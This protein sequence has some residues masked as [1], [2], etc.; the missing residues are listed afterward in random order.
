[1]GSRCRWFRP[2]L[3]RA[4][5]FLLGFLP[6]FLLPEPAEETLPEAEPGLALVEVVEALAGRVAVPVGDAVLLVEERL[7]VVGEVA[8]LHGLVL[9]RRAEALHEERAGL[10]AVQLAAVRAHRLGLLGG[11]RRDRGDL[12]GRRQRR[13]D[14]GVARALPARDRAQAAP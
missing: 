10:L 7:F 1:A 14:R 4:L 3:R 12:A 6:G 5:L 2:D 11:R 9:A 13:H 8:V